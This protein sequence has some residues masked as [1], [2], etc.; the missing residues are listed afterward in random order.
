M[1]R[2]ITPTRGLALAAALLLGTGALLASAHGH[3]GERH[4]EGGERG[5]RDERGGGRAA[6]STPA[7]PL[8]TQE[9]G[10]C[11]IAFAPALLPAASWQRQMATLDRHY[12]SDA[13]LDAATTRTLTDWLLANAGT[14]G[15]AQRDATPPPADRITRAPWFVRE[16]REVDAATWKRPA[17]KSAANCA[18]C[19]PKAEQG[20]FNEHGIR[21]P[22]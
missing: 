4:G 8:Y 15:R 2:W 13:S 9:C 14:S 5:E 10:S 7:L 21:I 11:H 18:A 16:H 1:T 19:H 6:T 20:D 22:R 3:D 17:I 12:G